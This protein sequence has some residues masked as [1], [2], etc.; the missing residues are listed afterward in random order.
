MAKDDE[1]KKLRQKSKYAAMEGLKPQLGFPTPPRKAMARARRA[2]K[3]LAYPLPPYPNANPV[4]LYRWASDEWRLLGRW[5]NLAAPVAIIVALLTWEKE[6]ALQQARWDELD[7]EETRRMAAHLY[8]A[9]PRTPRKR[10]L[11][12]IIPLPRRAK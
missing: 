9:Y 2:S 10:K 5:Q 3:K 1:V 4:Q 11:L 12:G 6:K 7:K 8:G